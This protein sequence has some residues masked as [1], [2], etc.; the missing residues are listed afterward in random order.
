MYGPKQILKISW[1]SETMSAQ[2]HLKFFG[3]YLELLLTP[4]TCIFTFLTL[5]F[6]MLSSALNRKQV[7]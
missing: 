6:T 4:E 3:F 5:Y 2:S 1:K 7:I